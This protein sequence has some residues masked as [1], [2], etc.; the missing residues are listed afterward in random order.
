MA[1]QDTKAAIQKIPDNDKLSIS[2][3]IEKLETM[4]ENARAEMRAGSESA[5]VDDNEIGDDLKL[6][7]QTLEDL[8]AE[9]VS[10]E[11]TGAATL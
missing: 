1:H 3:R 10:I 8:A 4:R 5:M 2:E 7:D 9:P 11:D 6:L